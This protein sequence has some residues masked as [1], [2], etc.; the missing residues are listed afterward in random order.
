MIVRHQPKKRVN[1][2]EK[3]ATVIKTRS[4]EES[5]SRYDILKSMEEENQSEEVIP[6][7]VAKQGKISTGIVENTKVR[8]SSTNKKAQK[9]STS[10]VDKEKLTMFTADTPKSLP[11]LRND[12]S[13]RVNSNTSTKSTN[14]STSRNPNLAATKEYHILVRGNNKNNTISRV[15]VSN[16]GNVAQ[17]D[18]GWTV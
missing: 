12:S 5:G 8:I 18:M 7:S 9:K 10:R 14:D 13:T 4:N 15:P 16:H 1:Q 3:N 17:A 6:K 2:Q 11:I